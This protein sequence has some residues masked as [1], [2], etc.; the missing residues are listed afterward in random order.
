MGRAL[1]V[2][3]GDPVYHVLN[4]ANGRQAF[5]VVRSQ[6]FGETSWVEATVDRLCLPTTQR[7]QGRPKTLKVGA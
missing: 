2:T 1:R 6:P 5:F 4:R 7:P 3:P